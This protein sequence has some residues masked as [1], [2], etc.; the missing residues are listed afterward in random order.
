LVL[1]QE[2]INKDR[3]LH[4]TSVGTQRRPLIWNWRS[5]H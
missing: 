4:Y 5:P 2:N 3:V 1:L